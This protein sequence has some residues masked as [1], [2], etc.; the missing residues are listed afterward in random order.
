[1]TP[2]VVKVVEQP[3]RETTVADIL[4]GAVGLV[5]AVLLAALVVGILVGGLFIL[6]R[7]LRGASLS[8]DADQAYRLNLSSLD[9]PP[10]PRPSQGNG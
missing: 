8:S 10:S 3:T 4:L 1:M 2:L 7:R 6:L 5:G 9:S